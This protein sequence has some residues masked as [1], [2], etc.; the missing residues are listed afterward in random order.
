ETRMDMSETNDVLVEFDKAG[1]NST[2]CPAGAESA[3][4]TSKAGGVA[5]GVPKKW[6]SWP[7]RHLASNMDDVPGKRVDKHKKD[8][9]MT[10]G[11]RFKDL[12]GTQ[13]LLTGAHIATLGGYL[14]DGLGTTWGQR[15]E[16]AS[17][18]IVGVIVIH[19]MGH[20]VRLELPPEALWRPGWLNLV[21][22]NILVADGVGHAYTGGQGTLIDY[23]VA[24]GPALDY[25]DRA[26]ADADLVGEGGKARFWRRRKQKDALQDFPRR[27]E[28]CS[29]MAS[30]LQRMECYSQ[31]LASSQWAGGQCIGAP[32][33]LCRLIKDKPAATDEF[34]D[35][36]IASSDPLMA[37]DIR[38]KVWRER[39]SDSP[40]DIEPASHLLRTAR[41]SF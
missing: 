15:G 17:R 27:K 35:G 33:E 11:V 39:W 2:V 31:C 40:F 20:L 23:V 38:A 34:E 29:N 22:V 24:S 13:V 5:V 14:Y 37:M 19:A 26:R 12:A 25:L 9:N 16:A 4:L 41:G 7:L 30:S 1:Y 10:T 18:G 8:H 32:G 3:H 21:Q 6:A 36:P 28:D